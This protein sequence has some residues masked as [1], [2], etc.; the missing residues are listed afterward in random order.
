MHF[1]IWTPVPHAVVPE[2]RL[3]AAAAQAQ[4]VVEA[5]DYQDQSFDFIR[6]VIVRA[7]QLGFEHTLIAERLLG[8]D[9]SA[10]MIS[11]ALAPLTRQIRLLCAIHPA[12]YPP[13][14]V[15]KMSASLDRISEGRFHLNLVTGW[16][17]EEYEM[18]SGSWLDR[19]EDRYARE[20]EYVQVI[21]GLWQQPDFS[22]QGQY[23]QLQHASLLVRPVQQPW[24]AIFA[25][26]RHEGGIDLIARE[27]DWW[28]ASGYQP[29]FRLWRTN[30]EII[31]AAIDSMRERA[32]RYDRA[33]HYAMSAHVI[34]RDSDDE[35]LAEADW[36]ADYGQTNRIAYIA[37]RHQSPGLIGTPDTIAERMLAYA[38]AGVEM[39]L[40]H[41]HPMLEGLERFAR[42]VAPRVRPSVAARA[43]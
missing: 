28:F 3:D 24:P 2:P 32:A 40:M 37:S 39:F 17:R 16:W 25:A 11:A 33:L 9:L 10:W 26:S 18:Y 4:A 20:L 23:Y 34:C 41:F 19:E 31:R 42:D 38:E 43:E 7:D 5:N 29:D 14:L 8:P 15:A 6:D 22:Y 30:V 21:K 1:G 12:L 13:Q 27:C 35:A 36:L